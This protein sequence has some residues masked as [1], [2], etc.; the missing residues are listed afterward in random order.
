M[1]R[2]LRL[3]VSN[4][5]SKRYFFKKLEKVW[6]LGVLTDGALLVGAVCFEV[7]PQLDI[8]V[9]EYIA[10]SSKYQKQGLGRALMASV[11]KYARGRGA[12]KL[13]LEAISSKS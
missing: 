6:S 8:G 10:I 2:L 4:L 11:E 12:S 1:L 13:G 9:L 7:K 5:I 3:N